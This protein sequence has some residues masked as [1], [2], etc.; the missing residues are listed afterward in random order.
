MWGRNLYNMAIWRNV[1]HFH[2][3]MCFFSSFFNLLIFHLWHINFWCITSFSRSHL[4]SPLPTHCVHLFMATKRVKCADLKQMP[5]D[6]VFHLILV[7]IT[8]HCVHTFQTQTH[9]Q[10]CVCVEIQWATRIR[11]RKTHKKKEV[12]QQQQQQQCEHTE[13]TA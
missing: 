8:K 1:T 13:S 11:N 4:L 10:Q 5:V 7:V 9:T 2:V 3:S 6:N 12:Q